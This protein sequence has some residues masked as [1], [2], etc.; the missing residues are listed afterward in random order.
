MTNKSLQ[1]LPGIN[2]PLNISGYIFR[3]LF[4]KTKEAKKINEK[5]K[6]TMLT[7]L[8]NGG[9]PSGHTWPNR[10]TMF[11]NSSIIKIVLFIS[12]S[13]LS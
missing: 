2:N 6:K 5:T 9:A 10:T 12:I 3:S 11:S 1:I 13:F 4:L 7:I 8:A